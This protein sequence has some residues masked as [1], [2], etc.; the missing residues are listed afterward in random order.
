MSDRPIFHIPSMQ[1]PA[2]MT[3]TNSF[4]LPPSAI[5]PPRNDEE[6]QTAI[7][8]PV[9]AVYEAFQTAETDSARDP[10]VV[11]SELIDVVTVDPADPV[12]YIPVTYMPDD[13]PASPDPYD[14]DDEVYS[15]SYSTDSSRSSLAS[16]RYLTTTYP[17]SRSSSRS[18]MGMEDFW[19][20]KIEAD[21]WGTE[22]FLQSWAFI[23][24]MER[25]NSG[26]DSGS[27]ASFDPLEPVIPDE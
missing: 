19:E 13:S 25:W 2:P 12:I 4:L 8:L 21:A 27:E 26:T 22:T 7:E 1:T 16:Y 3:A 23:E 10:A 18:S 15:C 17:N 9:E 5:Q 6:P 11:F 20:E 24:H 14:A